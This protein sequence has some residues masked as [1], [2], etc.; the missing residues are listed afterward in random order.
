VT[1]GIFSKGLDVLTPLYTQVFT[2]NDWTGATHN[3]LTVIR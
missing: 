1:H 2:P 3:A